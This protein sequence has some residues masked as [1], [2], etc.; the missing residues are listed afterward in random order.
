MRNDFKIG[1]RVKVKQDEA[2]NFIQPWR[3]R[4]EKGRCGTI[5][6]LRSSAIRGVKVK[7]DHG[8]VKWPHEWM[9]VHNEAELE[10]VD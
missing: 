6:S 4:F 2:Q 7:W 9:M 3:S 1:D 10:R 8:K 5:I